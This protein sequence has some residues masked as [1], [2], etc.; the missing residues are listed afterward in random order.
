MGSGKRSQAEELAEPRPGRRA[1][2]WSRSLR[3]RGPLSTA[4]LPAPTR[5]WSGSL[6]WGARLAESERSGRGASWSERTGLMNGLIPAW[7]V[8]RWAC[9]PQVWVI[10]SLTL[11]VGGCGRAAAELVRELVAGAWR[12]GGA[13]ERVM[14]AVG[15]GAEEQLSRWAREVPLIAACTSSVRFSG[16]L[17]R[18]GETQHGQVWWDSCAFPREAENKLQG[19][20][21]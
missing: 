13:A 6:H 20:F 3:M 7:C 16:A 8:K 12:P 4:L 15:V 9:G 14:R 2:P 1:G 10:M 21:F 11:L 17:G 18:L 19:L 5:G